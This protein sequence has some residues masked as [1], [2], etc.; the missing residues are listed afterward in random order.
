MEGGGGGWGFVWWVLSIFQW[1]CVPLGTL[2]FTFWAVGPFSRHLFTCPDNRWE[3]PCRWR[4]QIYLPRELSSNGP[5]L[6]SNSGWWLGREFKE[7]G[8]Y[9]EILPFP[10]LHVRDLHSQLSGHSQLQLQ[11]T[12]WRYTTQMSLISCWAPI[13]L[14][15]VVVSCGG[16]VPQFS[17]AAWNAFFRVCFTFVTQ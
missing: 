8:Q 9:E 4:T 6:S 1:N 3:Q 12:W 13:L 7:L 17:C 14:A 11:W 10:Y 5:Q 2:R 15:P 16:E